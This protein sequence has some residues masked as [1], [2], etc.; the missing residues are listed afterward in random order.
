MSSPKIF[1]FYET[2]LDKT[3]GSINHGDGGDEIKAIEVER[4]EECDDAISTVE[5]P[6]TKAIPGKSVTLWLERASALSEIRRLLKEE[7]KHDSGECFLAIFC[8]KPVP[9]RN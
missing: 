1:S 2:A 5:K 9:L 7:I 3:D 4:E 6:L 8:F